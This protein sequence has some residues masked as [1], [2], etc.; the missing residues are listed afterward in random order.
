MIEIAIIATF[1]LAI[2]SM[3]PKK[4]NTNIPGWALVQV[5]KESPRG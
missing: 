5:L 2:L 3:R 4:Q 1:A